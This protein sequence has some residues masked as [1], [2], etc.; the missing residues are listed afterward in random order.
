MVVVIVTGWIAVRFFLPSAG[1]KGKFALGGPLSEI[2]QR[3][4]LD[5]PDSSADTGERNSKGF[6]QKIAPLS[7]DEHQSSLIE[8]KAKKSEGP[9]DPQPS[10]ET[11]FVFPYFLFFV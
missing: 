5:A 9:A 8:K 11:R 10:W 6:M 4:M 3:L 7:P 1:K 2:E